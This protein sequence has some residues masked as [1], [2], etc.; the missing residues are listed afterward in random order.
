MLNGN[1]LKCFLVV[2]MFVLF[3]AY[4]Q[5]NQENQA[6]GTAEDQTE[7]TTDQAAA[8]DEAAQ[9]GAEGDDRQTVVSSG[10]GVK[11]REVVVEQVVYNFENADRWYGQ[12]F[13][14][15]GLIRVLKRRG[16]PKVLRDAQPENTEFV[17]GAKVNFLRRSFSEAYIS[18][19]AEIPINGFVK[20]MSIWAVGVDAP[21]EVYALVRD[22]EGKLFELKFNPNLQYLGWRKLEISIPTS[23]RDTNIVQDFPP[24]KTFFHR[25]GI[26]FLGLKVKFYAF[27][28]VGEVYF[29][30][31]QLSVEKD[32]YLDN[33]D[34][35]QQKLPADERN[36]PLN[37]W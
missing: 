37:D 21:H 27:D 28:A 23:P 7:E 17:L 11:G 6:D 10:L 8:T 29:Y 30:F 26:T 35:E 22:I 16:G 3:Y 19:P 34:L 1:L 14:D 13:L 18:P 25:R 36:I 9:P 20:K 31:D 15:N 2:V 4:S 5:E 24:N 33:L 32:V 12:M